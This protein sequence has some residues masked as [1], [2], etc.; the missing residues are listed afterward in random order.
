M[1]DMAWARRMGACVA[2]AALLAGCASRPAAPVEKAVIRSVAL[3]PATLPQ[4]YSLEN[5]TAAQFIAPIIGI[6]YRLNSR[7]K[8]RLLT[9]KLPAPDFRIDRD[10]TT[11]VAE[12]LRARGY[13]VTVLDDIP[14][15]EGDPDWFRYEEVAHSADVLLHVY[16]SDVGVESPRTSMQYL[17]RLNV[18][19]MSYVPKNASWP[20]ETTLYYGIDASAGTDH[21]I[22][23]DPRHAFPDFDHMMGNLD[24]V[25][26]GFRQP[27]AAIGQR[28]AEQAH[29]AFR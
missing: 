25:R 12:G 22:V 8:A 28:I 17:P 13:Q 19:V 18:S 11:A 9:E 3:V 20:Y 14:R 24:A 26:A 6:G 5:K 4:Q 29:A 27:I 16:F 21:S 10:L 1:V 15:L 2:A 7:Q 23:A